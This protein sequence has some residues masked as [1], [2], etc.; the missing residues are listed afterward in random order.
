MAPNEDRGNGSDYDMG[1][2]DGPFTN[3]NG[4]HRCLN[5]SIGINTLREWERSGKVKS[6]R[7][8]RKILIPR[9]ELTDLP[10]RLLAEEGAA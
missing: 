5:G 4:L 2:L 10:K 8:G 7:V 3:L 6:V 1:V 9:S